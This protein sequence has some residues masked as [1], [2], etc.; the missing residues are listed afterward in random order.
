METVF[1]MVD[2]GDAIKIYEAYEYQ[3]IA[4]YEFMESHK[5]EI[6]F[7]DNE[8]TF[9]L[10]HFNE[11]YPSFCILFQNNSYSYLSNDLKKLEQYAGFMKRCFYEKN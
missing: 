2:E 1:I 4:Y 9:I 10:S 3:K 6:V 11:K 5:E 7:N 8:N